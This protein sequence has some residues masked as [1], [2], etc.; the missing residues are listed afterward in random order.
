MQKRLRLVILMSICLFCLDNINYVPPPVPEP[1]P[2]V[3]EVIDDRRERLN[4]RKLWLIYESMAYALHVASDIPGDEARE[5]VRLVER[6]TLLYEDMDHLLVLGLIVVESNGN[7]RAISPVGA[8]GLMQIMPTTGQFIAAHFE[9]KWEGKR[10]LYDV[11]RN[12]RYGVWYLSHLQEQFPDNKQAQVAA[13][14]WGPPNIRSRLRRGRTLPKVYPG[15]VEEA[16]ERIAKEMYEFHKEQYWR[17]LDLSKDPPYFQ[18]HPTEPSGSPRHPVILVDDGE[19]EL[20]R[21]GSG[22]QQMSKLVPG[23]D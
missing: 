1:E 16:R 4:E 18:D 12:I 6:E 21:E 22:V 9:E 14:N 15:K 17:S 7:D 8:R 2:V 19:S 20:L 11:E 3:V 23:R 10:S 5:I 13:Y